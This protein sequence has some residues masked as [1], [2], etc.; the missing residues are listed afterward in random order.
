MGPC[1]FSVPG[2]CIVD[3][4]GTI[5]AA[6]SRDSKIMTQAATIKNPEKNI[7]RFPDFDIF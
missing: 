1:A 5:L 3:E 6:V 4:T 2:P 7:C